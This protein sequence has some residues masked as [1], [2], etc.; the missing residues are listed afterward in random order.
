MRQHLRLLQQR[1][2]EVGAGAND[3]REHKADVQHGPHRGAAEVDAEPKTGTAE[4]RYEVTL[5]H[6]TVRKEGYELD[7]EQ[8]HHADAS[9]GV[10]HMDRTKAVRAEQRGSPVQALA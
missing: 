6:K 9:A 3:Q 1:R 7:C 10:R 5:M 4:E 8:H 2:V